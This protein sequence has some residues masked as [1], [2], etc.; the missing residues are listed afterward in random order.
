MA[1][2][3]ALAPRLPLSWQRVQE[4]EAQLPPI[5]WKHKLLAARAYMASIKYQMRAISLG[6]SPKPSVSPLLA[7]V[8]ERLDVARRTRQYRKWMARG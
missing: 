6:R 2:A 8:L 7:L 3:L 1:S 5:R 4:V